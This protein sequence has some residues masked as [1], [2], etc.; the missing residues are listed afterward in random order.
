MEGSGTEYLYHFSKM[1]V[2]THGST[3]NE[4]YAIIESNWDLDFYA[5]AYDPQDP[6]SCSMGYIWTNIIG[7][8]SDNDGAPDLYE[9]YGEADPYDADNYPSVDVNIYPHITPTKV[10]VFKDRSEERRVG[11]ECR[12]R[13]SPYH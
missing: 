8:D 6:S 4:C 11:K 1:D 2:V 7:G 5:R 10:V 9:I 3:S 12:S 13:W